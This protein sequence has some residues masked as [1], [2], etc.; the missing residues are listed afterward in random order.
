M[1]PSWRAAFRDKPRVEH[2]DPR[3]KTIIRVA[4]MCLGQYKECKYE[5]ITRIWTIVSKYG[6]AWSDLLMK[7]PEKVDRHENDFAAELS[8]VYDVADEFL[9]T[10]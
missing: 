2:L 10:R 3:C 7:R 9:Q 1:D 8:S 5:E 4:E 6:K